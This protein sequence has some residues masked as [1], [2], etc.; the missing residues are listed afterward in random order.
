MRF[1]ARKSRLQSSLDLVRL[2]SPPTP[3][4]W[5]G[6]DAGIIMNENENTPAGAEGAPR[7]AT[8]DVSP[9]PSRSAVFSAIR[10]ILRELLEEQKR[11]NKVV[12]YQLRQIDDPLTVCSL[13]AKHG[14]R[15]LHYTCL[16]IFIAR[17]RKCCFHFGLCHG[18]FVIAALVMVVAENASADDRKIRIRSHEIMRKYSHEIQ[19]IGERLS[20]YVHRY[21]LL[22]ENDA[23]LVVVN[24]RAVL[25]EEVLPAE[26]Y[27]DDAVILPGRMIEPAGIAFVLCAEQALRISGSFC[28]PC[29]CYGLRV[30]LR[31]GQVY[32]NI[33]SSVTRVHSPLAVLCD[34]VSSD[35]TGIAREAIIPFGSRFRGF[36]ISSVELLCD[37]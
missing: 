26:L 31:L 14:H 19:Q 5:V 22:V 33:Q 16:Y 3:S 27:R 25:H 18:E 6:I 10:S 32:R 12:E 30:F 35:V 28:F 20:V 34:T 9:D 2:T 24:I 1:R 13:K 4:I 17:Y 7:P 23:V 37:L 8:P 21:M 29:S 11:S 36:L 15:P